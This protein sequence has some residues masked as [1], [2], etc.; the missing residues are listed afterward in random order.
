MRR[1]PADPDGNLLLLAG[2]AS[3]AR[4]FVVPGMMVLIGRG[5]TSRMNYNSLEM[6]KKGRGTRV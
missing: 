2:M 4:T 1:R 6:I 5:A 3:H